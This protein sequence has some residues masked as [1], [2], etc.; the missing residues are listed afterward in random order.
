[1][2]LIFIADYHSFGFKNKTDNFEK[3]Y[4]LG[5]EVLVWQFIQIHV[6]CSLDNPN[7]IS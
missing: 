7:R 2:L 4:N 3:T 5:L 6:M 1:M